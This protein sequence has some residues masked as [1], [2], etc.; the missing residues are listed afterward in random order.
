[1]CSRKETRRASHG[2]SFPINSGNSSKFLKMRVSA[3]LPNSMELGSECGLFQV[4]LWLTRDRN[5][6][7]IITGIYSMPSMGQALATHITF[8]SFFHFHSNPVSY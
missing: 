6:E 4:Q 5:N 8:V 2:T 7:I 3:F 1:M